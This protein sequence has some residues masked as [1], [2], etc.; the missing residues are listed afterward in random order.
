LVLYNRAITQISGNQFLAS[1]NFYFPGLVSTH[2]LVIKAAF[3][4]RD[5]LDQI[6]FSNSFPFSRGYS[7]ENFYQM[8]G[9]GINYNFP[10]VYPDWGFAELIY[11]LRIRAN[12][13][14][15]YTGVPYYATN[16]PGVQSQIPPA[17]L[18]VYLTQ[19]GGT[20]CPEFWHP[21]QPVVDP[22]YGGRGPNQWKYPSAEYPD[23]GYNSKWPIRR[24]P[25]HLP[26][27]ARFRRNQIRPQY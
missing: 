11:F 27:F 23:K 22:D 8:A 24:D 14:Y 18:E 13:F 19:N 7:G 17:G 2:S 12:V 21:L 10:L 1:G 5:S 6:R 3:Q 15:D 4:Q 26:N 9:F 16:G 25:W 20:N